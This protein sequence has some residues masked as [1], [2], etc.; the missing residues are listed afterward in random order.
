MSRLTLGPTQ[1]PI[2]WVQGAVYALVKWQGGEDD[3]PLPSCEVK[4]G[5]AISLPSHMRSLCGA[6]FVF[7]FFQV[8]EV[9]D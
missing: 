6:Q 7:C 2:Q 9:S 3:H 1:S 4:N 8:S 5:R